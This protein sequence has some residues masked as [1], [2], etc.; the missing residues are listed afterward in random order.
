MHP[1]WTWGLDYIPYN[2]NSIDPKVAV[3]RQLYFRQAFEYLVDQAAVIQGALHGYG[4]ISTGPVGDAPS[5]AYLSPQAKKGDPFPFNLGKAKTLL[6]EHGW[7]VNPPSGHFKGQTYCVNA[8]LCGP[9]IA[10]G[11][12]LDFDLYYVSGISWVEASV[13]QLKSNAALLGIHLNLSSGSFDQVVGTVENGCGSATVPK[14]CKWELADWGQGW[15]YQPDYLPTGDELY[16]TG[17][18]GNLGDYSNA[19]NDRYIKATVQA[20]TRTALV[21]AM[22]AWENYLTPQLP[23]M[24]QPEAPSA[25]M[26][27]VDNLHIGIQNPTLTI[28]PEDWYFTH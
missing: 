24:L 15:S 27:T 25:L 14:P 17:S 6:T 4:I 20:P 7:D 28:N 16:E 5:T 22:Y 1:L 9:G 23:V 2:F 13:L 3:F 8:A 11:T 26:E 18:A 10:R 19:T 12:T 21:K